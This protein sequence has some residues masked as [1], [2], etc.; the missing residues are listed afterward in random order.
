MEKLHLSYFLIG[1]NH[2]VK[3]GEDSDDEV[4]SGLG[5]IWQ[6]LLYPHSAVHA[7]GLQPHR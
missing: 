5:C 3:H 1:F 6:G 4:V 7:V 2:M